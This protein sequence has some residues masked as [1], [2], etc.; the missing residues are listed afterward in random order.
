MIFRDLGNSNIKASVIGMGTWVTGGWMWGGANDDESIGA[1]HASLDNGVNLIDTAPV[2]GFGRSEEV[3]GRAIADRRDKVILAT[4]CGLVWDRKKGMFYVYSDEN[5]VKKEGYTKE[6][7]KYLGP[8]SIRDEVVKSLKRLNTDYIDLYQTHWQE[9]TTPI[10]DT[11]SEL[12]KLKDE[13]KIRAIGVSNASVAHMKEYGEI[14]SAQEKYNLLHLVLDRNGI[15][16]Y[17][18]QNNIAILAYSPL[19]NGLLTGKFKPD[20]VFNE[21]DLRKGN[22]LYAA[23]NIEKVNHMLGKMKPLA[24]EMDLSISQLV[25]RWTLKRK[26]ITHLLVGARTEKQASENSFAGSKML[27]E[28]VYNKIEEIRN[29]FK[30]E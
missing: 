9:E 18:H 5:R 28:E 20:T 11:M 27:D 7:Y 22:K 3:V 30:Y 21:N 25:M 8:E 16:D 24:D 13:G 4:K 15:T 12:L 14:D 6:V 26:G 19:A 1:I 10:A 23:S 17:C 2:Y 29:E